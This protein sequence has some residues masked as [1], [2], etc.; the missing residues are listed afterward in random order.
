MRK[1]SNRAQ[2]CLSPAQFAQATYSS[3]EPCTIYPSRTRAPCKSRPILNQLPLNVLSPKALWSPPNPIVLALPKPYSYHTQT[4]PK[5]YRSLAEGF[6]KA[7]FYATTSALRSHPFYTPSA[8]K[9]RR[10]SVEG[11]Q[12]GQSFG[13][14]STKPGQSLGGIAYRW[15]WLLQ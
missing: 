10:R 11:V 7:H 14:T 5:P 8:N 6:P 15:R 4:L 13:K 3:P 1:C 9:E 2:F 12:K